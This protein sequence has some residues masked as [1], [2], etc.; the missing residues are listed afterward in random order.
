MHTYKNPIIKRSDAYNTADPYV[1]RHD[2]YYYHCYGNETGVYIT[3]AKELWDIGD[4]E[5][6]QV[7]DCSQEGAL[8]SWFAP[9]LHRLD[10]KWYIYAAPNYDRWLHVMTVLECD[11]ES[12]C[13]RYENRGM[14]RGLEN[15]WSIDGTILTYGGE[16]YFVWTSCAELYIAKMADPYSITG[17]V[18]VLTKPEYAFETRVGLVNEGP[19]VLYKNDKIHIAYSANDSRDDAYCLGL[20]TF[21]GGDILEASNWTKSEHAVFEQ[22]A[23]IFGPGHCSFT[24]VTKGGEEIDYIVYHANLVSGSGWNGRNVFVQPFTWDADDMPVFGKPQFEEE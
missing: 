24:T 8:P 21:C 2:G 13:G 10:G 11:G 12:P 19:A 14:M 5:T 16:R 15:K 17:K 6:I 1:L 7:Y 18:T 9:E 22:T 20:L 23:E 3:K 4:G